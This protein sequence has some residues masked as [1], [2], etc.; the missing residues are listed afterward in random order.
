ML[1]LSLQ[2][3]IHYRNSLGSP[4]NG[5]IKCNTNGAFAYDSTV[6]GSDVIFRNHLGNFVLTYA[7]RFNCVSPLH[8]EFGVVIKAMEI[9]INRGWTK[10]W[11]ETDSLLM[12]KALS[13]CSLV[14]WMFRSRW[15]SC[16][17]PSHFNL[18]I[19]HIYKEGNTCADFLANFAL[20][21]NALAF[22]DS[23]LLGIQNDF[24]KNMLKLPFF[25][26]S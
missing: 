21:T 13:N 5:W 23:I 24:V 3:T 14:P 7:E 22:F 26:F 16:I 9:A 20:D 12:T 6:V 25:I 8:A 19:T 2:S 4:S 1:L 10:L 15:I 18:V 17:H 11:L